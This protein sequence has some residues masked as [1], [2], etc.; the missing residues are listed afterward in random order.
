MAQKQI[1]R[2]P[3]CDDQNHVIGILTIGD[4]CHNEQ[5]IGTQE[6]TKTLENICECKPNAQNAE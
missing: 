3:V 1:I 6:V 4:L 5:K 2:L